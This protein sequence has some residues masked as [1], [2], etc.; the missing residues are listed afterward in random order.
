[1]VFRHRGTTEESSLGW[2]VKLKLA[3]ANRCQ[4]LYWSG[5]R[6]LLHANKDTGNRN[7]FELLHL[8]LC[9]VCVVC[10]VLCV[11]CVGVCF[12]HIIGW[13]KCLTHVFCRTSKWLR[14][15]CVFV[16]STQGRPQQPSACTRPGAQTSTI[17][18]ARSGFWREPSM[19]LQTCAGA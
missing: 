16:A 4:V 14:M 12:I 6:G 17:P 10:C 19:I 2:G 13:F 8:M 1:M 9:Y 15:L 7:Y 5:M 3:K 11:Y 18:Q